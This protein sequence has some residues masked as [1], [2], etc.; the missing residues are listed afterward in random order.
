MIKWL[1]YLGV[2]YN[3]FNEIIKYFLIFPFA[4]LKY[5]KKKI[6]LVS[7]S[8]LTARDNG[9][10]FYKYLKQN[11]PEI[12]SYY[13]ISKKS[14]D[15]QKVKSLG[16]IVEHKSFKNYC[17]F[18]SSEVQLSTQILGC[19]PNY[20]VYWRL[21]REK[22]L[23]P[24]L[25]LQSK[26]IF[27]QHGIIKDDMPQFY[28]E[29][30][31]V[32]VFICGAKPEY[33]YICKTYHYGKEVKYTGLAR[34]DNLYDQIPKKQVLVMPTWRNWLIY[35]QENGNESVIAESNYVKKWNSFLHSDLLSEVLDSANMELIFYPHYAMQK[36]VHL[37]SSLNSHIT[38]ADFDHYDVQQL[39]KESS[40]LVTDYSSVY[41]DFAYMKKPVLYYQFDREE[42]RMGHYS[43]G[44]FD[45]DT[46]GFGEVAQRE[47]E[48]I[49]YIE[50]YIQSDFKLSEKYDVRSQ[51]FFLLHDRKN[52]K[53]IYQEVLNL[54]QMDGGNNEG[55][56]IKG[57]K[58]R[59]T[60]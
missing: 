20:N 26:Q 42:Y 9:Y 60:F 45:Y 40:L 41:F 21:A 30:A 8:G 31:G 38:I 23:W 5:R 53:R 19:S 27:L 29:N 52:C 50:R 57:S 43:Q 11:H 55:E 14:A 59:K 48:L 1:N 28:K 13:V 56:T 32:D 2:F 22:K 36:Y 7:E 34:F 18:I 54:L 51:G 35:G 16:N 49:N 46:M 10:H 33:D 44:Y 12:E 17:L 58:A 4:K 15:Y 47:E 6:W 37:F 25:H 39:L 24:L 3:F